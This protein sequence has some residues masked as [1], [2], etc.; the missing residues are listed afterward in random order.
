MPGFAVPATRFTGVPAKVAG[1]VGGATPRLLPGSTRTV[2]VPLPETPPV[3]ASTDSLLFTSTLGV[4]VP[5]EL[6]ASEPLP[7]APLAV[8]CSVPALTV[9]P[10]P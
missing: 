5:A 4:A 8:V 3:K 6:T 7:S 2:A 1:P 10:P 9:L